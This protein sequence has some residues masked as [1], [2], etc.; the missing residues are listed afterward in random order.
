[1]GDIKNKKAIII[2]GNV[3]KYN[4]NKKS[5]IDELI[6][7]IRDLLT[8]LNYK[9]AFTVVQN[10]KSINP[11]TFLNKGKLEEIKNLCNYLK[12]D[13]LVFVNNLTPT[14]FR[15]LENY[16][17]D[18][19]FE[20]MDRVGIILEIFAKRAKTLEGKLQVELARLNYLLPRITGYGKILSRLGGGIK[21]RGPGEMKLTIEKRKIL[22]RI[23]SIK[24]KLKEVEKNRENQRKNRIKSNLP[25]VSII[26]YTNAGKSTLFNLLTKENVL[27]DEKVFATL[28]P[29]SSKAYIDKDFYIILN[30]TVGFVRDLPQELL[31]AFKATFEELKYSDL[32]ILLFDISNENVKEHIK[33]TFDIITKINL[34]HIPYIGVFNKIDNV[35]DKQTLDNFKNEFKDYL[36]ISAKNKINIDILKNKIKEVLTKIY[37]DY[38]LS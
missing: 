17:K 28:D 22:K 5:Y 19:D 2:A 26:G 25:I 36:F 23:N 27:V 20:I 3:Y 13:L 35:K 11:A 33:H 30:D 37:F 9:E 1:M 29:V 12:P 4:F 32:F 31:N 38:K 6:Q 14:Q 8:F 10:L 21:T 24:E 16:F 18:Q 7:E 15:N 34:N